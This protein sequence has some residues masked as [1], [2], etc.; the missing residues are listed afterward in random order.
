VLHF[1][2]ELAILIFF[3]EDYTYLSSDIPKPNNQQLLGESEH[4]AFGVIEFL[5]LR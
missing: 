4:K 1:I 3:F 2:I 5:H